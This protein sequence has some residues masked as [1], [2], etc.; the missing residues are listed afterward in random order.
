MKCEA[1]LERKIIINFS[2]YNV[3]F[4]ENRTYTG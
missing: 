1:N 2:I 4:V 3:I